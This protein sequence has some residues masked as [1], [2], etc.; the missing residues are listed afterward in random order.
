M[1]ITFKSFIRDGGHSFGAVCAVAVILQ[2]GAIAGYAQTGTYPYSGSKRTIT[3]N[4]G[5]Y[6]I[7]VYGA[8]GGHGQYGA[9]GGLGA[10]LSA[11]FSF[12]ALRTLTLLVGGGGIA[13]TGNSGGG[14]GGSF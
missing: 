2:S 13:G 4:S 5:T 7:T 11:E 12:S 14:G 6:D 3:L 8:Q 9:V 10:E 1:K